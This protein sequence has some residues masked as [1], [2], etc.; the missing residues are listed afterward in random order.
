MNPSLTYINMDDDDLSLLLSEPDTASRQEAYDA[1]VAKYWKPMCCL[2][3]DQGITDYSDQEDIVV[4]AFRQFHRYAMKGISLDGENFRQLLFTVVKRRGI[5]HLRRKGAERRGAEA[6]EDYVTNETRAVLSAE[7]ASMAWLDRTRDGSAA[8]IM[9]DF[10]KAVPELP[11]Q[12][13]AA[14]RAV[15]LLLESN[16]PLSGENIRDAMQTFTGG[17]VTLPAAKSAWAGV[18]AKFREL[19]KN[20]RS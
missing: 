13:E 10:R 11:R 3:K 2:L 14:A 17:P 20:R 4:V 9:E 15:S 19:L 16:S 1:I 18:R 7:N 12:Q 5:D 8:A 6:Y